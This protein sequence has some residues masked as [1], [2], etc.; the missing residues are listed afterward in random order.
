MVKLHANGSKS[1][2]VFRCTGHEDALEDWFAMGSK[3]LYLI[4]HGQAHHNVAASVIGYEAYKSWE[5]MDAR[6]GL[7]YRVL[8]WCSLC[9]SLF[10]VFL[11]QAG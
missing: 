1:G 11:V 7:L 3:T 8:V 10:G 6:W 9:R 5:Y 2:R 4:R